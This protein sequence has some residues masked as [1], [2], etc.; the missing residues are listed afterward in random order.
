MPTTFKNRKLQISEKVARSRREETYQAAL[1]IHGGSKSAE[2]GLLDT[3]NAKCNKTT[4]VE[5]LS[6]SDKFKRSVLPQLYK[7]SLKDFEGSEENMLRSVSVYYDRGIMGKRKY[8]QV[9]RNVSFQKLKKEKKYGKR[10]AIDNCP[11]PLLVPYNKLMPFVKSIYIGT[12]YSTYDS[13]C[14][15]LE[16]GDKIQGCYRNLKELLIMLAEFY[17]VS[18]PADLVWFDEA[19]TFY[20]ALGGDGAPF[21]KYDVACAWL[22]SFL[23]LGKGVLSSNENY[24]LFGANCS[25]SCVPVSRFIQKLMIEVEEIEKQ[26][27][28]INVNGTVVSVKF[29]I[30]ELP[31]DMKML[32]YLAG[33]LSNSA[34]Y[35]STFAK[36]SLD[37]CKN[38]SG[39]FGK[40]KSNTWRPWEYS[41][42]LAVAKAVDIQKRKVN[43]LSIK[44]STKRNKITSFIAQQSSRQEFVPLVGKLIDQA[45]VDP[46]HLIMPALWPIVIY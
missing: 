38:T 23:N 2:V 3:V 35:F 6:T 16:D 5:V 4:L 20:I 46:L 19:N 8:R 7:V 12:V 41:K 34:K 24:L 11:I 30:A 33:E 42:R 14:D 21:G 37:D 36:V 10:I 28:P 32:A 31:N 45:H 13:L 25:E 40:E 27:F 39:S 43:K 15:G 29:C 17:L 18:R 22:V 26:V 1:E 44:P 9:Y